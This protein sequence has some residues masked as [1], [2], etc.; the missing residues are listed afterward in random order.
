MIEKEFV[1]IKKNG[2]RIAG[3]AFIPQMN[4]QRYPTV[5]FSHGF[6]ENYRSFQHHGVGFCEA[7]IV[8]ILFDFCGGGIESLSDGKLQEMTVL[9]EIE[10]LQTMIDA[11]SEFDYVDADRMFL[12]GESMGGFV[13]AFVAAQRNDCI[14]ALILWYPA[15]VI[16]DDSKRRLESGDNMCFGLKLC[17]DF[18]KVAADIDIY[19]IISKYTGPVKIIHGDQD[20][21]VSISYSHHAA[22]VYNDASLTVM[23]GAGHGFDDEDSERARKESIEFIMQY[24]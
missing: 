23:P 6:N 22:D 11:V 13:S 10:D 19:S 17:P 14:K 15:F 5:I 20:T 2:Y 18:N 1:V 24:I 9:T 7:G 3:K 8:C 21:V 4:N 12:Q 16:P